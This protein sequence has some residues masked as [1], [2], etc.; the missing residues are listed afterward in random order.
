VLGARAPVAAV[1]ATPAP[2]AISALPPI[3]TAPERTAPVWAAPPT[4]AS[5]GSSVAAPATHIDRHA[6]P[7][8]STREHEDRQERARCR[9][10][11]K[12]F[13]E[14]KG[15]GFIRGDDGRDAFVHHSAIATPGFRSLAQGQAVE[16]EVQHSAKGLQAVSV[17]SLEASPTRSAQ[18]ARAGPSSAPRP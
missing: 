6:E 8:P 15:Y 13:S 1:E 2:P 16:Y 10:T 4:E 18:P 12:W 7:T 17:T 3:P 14:A 11:V 9:G 5:P